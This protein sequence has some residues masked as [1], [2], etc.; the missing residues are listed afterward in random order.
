MSGNGNRWQGGGVNTELIGPS[1]VAER[2][3]VVVRHAKSARPDGVPDIERPLNARGRRDAPELGR[4]ITARVGTPDAVRCSPAERARRTWELAAT[5]F[6]DTPQAM[7]VDRIYDAHPHTLLGVVRELPDS[8]RTAVLVGHNPGV[9]DLVALLS[10]TAI[11]MPTAAVAV[12]GWARPWTK[13]GPAELVA[14][15]VPRG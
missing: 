4:W 2:R 5:G 13:S 1:R 3:L 6:P 9:E 14:H 8:V 12:L 11:P 7:I 15:A 10:G